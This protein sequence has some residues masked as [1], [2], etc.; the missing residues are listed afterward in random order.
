LLDF[1]LMLSFAITITL[2]SRLTKNPGYSFD[3]RQSRNETIQYAGRFGIASSSNNN[4]N[5]K[6]KKV[7]Q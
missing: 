6:K 3:V 1:F 2:H 7:Q 5:E 4:N